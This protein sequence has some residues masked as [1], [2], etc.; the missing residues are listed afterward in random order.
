MK[1]AKLIAE[2]HY[3]GTGEEMARGM[4]E[5]IVA[6]KLEPVKKALSQIVNYGHSDKCDG[7]Y[8]D[9]LGRIDP[10]TG[11]VYRFNSCPIYECDCGGNANGINQWDIAK[12]AL[13]LF[14]EGS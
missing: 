14:E 7:W 3:R 4:L 12:A 8:D 13:A 9:K 10:N 1:L 5:N 6:A 11:I 2:E